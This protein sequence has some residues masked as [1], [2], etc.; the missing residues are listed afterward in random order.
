[1]LEIWRM[2]PKPDYLG[3]VRIIAVDPDQAVGVVVGKTIQ[4][5]QIKEGDIVSSS[6]NNAPRS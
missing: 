5:K 6:F 3:K 4:G 1:V 2:K